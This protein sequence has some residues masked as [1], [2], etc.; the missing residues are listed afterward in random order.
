MPL[1]K[2]PVSSFGYLDLRATFTRDVLMCQNDTFKKI[3]K[4]ERPE[5]DGDVDQRNGFNEIDRGDKEVSGK[6]KQ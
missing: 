3:T 1:K 4:I 6:Q 2:P 5:F